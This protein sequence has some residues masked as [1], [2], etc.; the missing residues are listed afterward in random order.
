VGVS[1]IAQIERATSTNLIS[2]LSRIQELVLGLQ[3]QGPFATEVLC[4][5]HS[6]TWKELSRCLRYIDEQY[7]TLVAGTIDAS[8]AERVRRHITKF[9]HLQDMTDS[10]P[11]HSQTEYDWTRWLLKTLPDLRSK[12]CTD[13]RDRIFSLYGLCC[14]VPQPLPDYTLTT[15]EVYL[16]F[17]VDAIRTTRSL[18]IL[19]EIEAR[20]NSSEMHLPS[21]VPDWNVIIG[22]YS[23]RRKNFLNTCGL[24][25][26]PDNLRVADISTLPNSNILHLAGIIF[27]EIVYVGDSFG[28]L[29]MTNLN[30]DREWLQ[31]VWYS[32]LCWRYT[33][34]G[35]HTGMGRRREPSNSVI[36]DGANRPEH[37][38]TELTMYDP[39]KSMKTGFW[40]G[41]GARYSDPAFARFIYTII[42]N[43]TVRGLD[44]L[45]K[46]GEKNFFGLL[47]HSDQTSATALPLLSRKDVKKLQKAQQDSKIDAIH[48]SRRREDVKKS[49]DETASHSNPAMVFEDAPQS[50]RAKISIMTEYLSCLKKPAYG[51]R[52]FVTRNGY[53]GLGVR[54]TTIGD[55]VAVLSTYGN[56]GRTPY[57]IRPNGMKYEFVGEAYVH[58]LNFDDG[59]ALHWEKI[60]LV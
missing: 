14:A 34:D 59:V 40:K 9:R 48:R 25:S 55:Q 18:N 7:A 51:R 56:I 31:A 19:S 50:R 8:D 38:R 46:D 54:S 45:I 27:D 20:S 28:S 32:L 58:E 41:R 26:I 35:D 39:Y 47:N 16:R 24:P 2:W 44:E 4:G 42:A 37:S 5:P 30:E 15:S 49:E 11:K 12:K 53:M 29:E 3:L 52:V 43:T 22:R 10:R 60:D 1:I 36:G 23:F 6:V 13:P 57:C 33:N 21:W 17:T